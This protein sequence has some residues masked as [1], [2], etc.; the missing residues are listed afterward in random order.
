MATGRCKAESVMVVVPSQRWCSCLEGLEEKECKALTIVCQE[1][2]SHQCHLGSHI[3]DSGLKWLLW[4]INSDVL[5]RQHIFFPETNPNLSVYRDL[6]ATNLSK[7]L[8]MNWLQM[9]S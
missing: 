6:Y 1:N 4:E 5:G 9:W 2:A 7:A 8:N 3:S